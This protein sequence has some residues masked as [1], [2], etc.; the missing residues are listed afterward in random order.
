LPQGLGALQISGFDAFI[1]LVSCGSLTSHGIKYS[2]TTLLVAIKGTSDSY[3][4]QWAE[5]AAASSRPMDLDE[6]TWRARFDT[7]NPINLCPVISGEA[8][9]YPSCLDKK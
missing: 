7:L 8:A 2:E 4:V 6:A 5:R 1:A 9:P 3:T